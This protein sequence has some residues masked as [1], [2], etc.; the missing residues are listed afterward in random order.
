MII[1]AWVL[2]PSHAHLIVST[3]GQP[4]SG[5]MRDLKKFT[6]KQIVKLLPNV[7]ESRRDWLIRAFAK[8]GNNLKRVKHFKVWQ[9]GNH[10]VSLNNNFMLEQRLTYV[11]QNPV[12]AEIVDEAEYYWYSSA[13]DYAGLKG[14]LK[15]ELL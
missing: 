6:S 10:P 8:A 1:H 5:I 3:N 12:R 13:R 9:D 14:L 2:M 4:H 11:H 15:V 7:N